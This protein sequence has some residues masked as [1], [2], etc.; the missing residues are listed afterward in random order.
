VLISLAVAAVLVV[1]SQRPGT[2]AFAEEGA[3]SNLL[4]FT[5]TWL[6]FAIGVASIVLSVRDAVVHGLEAQRFDEA[7]RGLTESVRLLLRIERSRLLE[8]EN[9]QPPNTRFSDALASLEE[10]RKLAQDRLRGGQTSD[11]FQEI[12]DATPLKAGLHGHSVDLGRIV[13]V[14]SESGATITL[15]P[16]STLAPSNDPQP[17]HSRRKSTLGREQ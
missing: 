10:L 13:K 8:A 17:P 3:G 1:L 9:S 2:L 7:A 4:F 16:S 14:R 12:V 11:L 15:A 5:A 6:A